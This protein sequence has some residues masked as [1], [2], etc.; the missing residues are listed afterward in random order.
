MHVM[1][2]GTRRALGVTV[3][4]AVVTSLLP[5]A[6]CSPSVDGLT[7]EDRRSEDMGLRRSTAAVGVDE[8]G[9]DTR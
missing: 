5:P 3:A 9:G 6:A 2:C 7:M 8:K 4:I 1:W